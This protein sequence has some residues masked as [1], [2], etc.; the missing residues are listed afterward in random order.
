M[1]TYMHLFYKHLN[2]SFADWNGDTDLYIAKEIMQQKNVS[3]YLQSGI[4]KLRIFCT[5]SS[6][7][8]AQLQIW[9]DCNRSA[10]YVGECTA[11]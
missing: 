9:V 11:C 5:A 4:S 6:S 8:S 3:F 2:L 10:A 1:C 7:A